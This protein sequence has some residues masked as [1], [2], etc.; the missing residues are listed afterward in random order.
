M[1]FCFGHWT[2]S[3][4]HGA[5]ELPQIHQR[6]NLKGGRS[7]SYGEEPHRQLVPGLLPTIHDAC[8]E[9]SQ[10]CF[11]LDLLF[12]SCENISLGTMIF[13]LITN[14]MELKLTMEINLWACL[15]GIMQIRSI[16]V[17][18]PILNLGGP[19]PWAGVPDWIKWRKW[20]GHLHSLLSA[21]WLWM[22]AILSQPWST[23]SPGT[24]NQKRPF[25]L[26]MA[27]QLNS[28]PCGYDLENSLLGITKEG[29]GVRGSPPLEEEDTKGSVEE[30]A[31]SFQIPRNLQISLITHV[32]NSEQG[33]FFKAR[34]GF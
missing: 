31:W 13:T 17:R 7:A 19:V 30:K 16:K 5:T 8:C 15:W 12:P 2:M 24:V 25:F 9:A 10:A 11:Q 21:S 33:M 18:R 3:A 32:L 26:K 22:Y 27:I 1:S 28:L 20:A 29:E 14:L 6:W 23:V 34:L 4:L